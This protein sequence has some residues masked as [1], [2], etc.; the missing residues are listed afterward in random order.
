MFAVVAFGRLITLRMYPRKGS[1]PSTFVSTFRKYITL[2]ATFGGMHVQPQRLGKVPVN[3][4]PTRWQSIV[5]F[6]FV[7]LNIILLFVDMW[8]VPNNTTYYTDAIMSARNIGDRAAYL[9]LALFPILFLFG[10][11]NNFLM[12]FTGWSFETFNV[13]HRWIGRMMFVNF[14]VHGWTYTY[15]YLHIGEYKGESNFAYYKG[16][17]LDDK[18][19]YLG[20]VAL[21]LIGVILIQAC[22]VLRHHWYEIFLVGHI[23]TV[24]CYLAT[25]WH[26]V[27]PHDSIEYFYAC[28]AIWGLD[29]LVRVCRILL[30]GPYSEAKITVHGD[31]VYVAVKPAVHF[32]PK[33]GQYAFLYVLRHNFWESHPF[34][35]VETRDKHYI[36]VAKAHAGLT[37]KIH[38]SVTKQNGNNTV[39][40][41]IEGPYGESYPIARYETV[42]LVAGGIG[43]TAIMSYAL[44]LKRRNTQQHVK[45]YWMVREQVSLAWVKDQLQELTEGGGLIDI[46]IYITGELEEVNEKAPSEPESTSISDLSEKGQAVLSQLIVKYNQRPDMRFVV[47]ETV[48]NAEGSVAVVSCGPGSLADVCRKAAV[49]NVDKG[50]GRVDYFEDAFSWA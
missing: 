47:A 44:D 31:A 11:R 13:F 27:K 5:V 10:G 19:N 2:P 50:A 38:N 49:E 35:I 42:L 39:R 32:H 46:H 30:A 23:A 17:I 22:Y 29:R 12:F 26:H 37:K 1:R 3:V 48:R 18:E 41:W 33:P 20:I 34:S 43:I 25:A 4:I 15:N 16:E 45:L 7:S 21:V 8:T 36:F 6:F 40:V 9:G 24:I 28:V 14:A